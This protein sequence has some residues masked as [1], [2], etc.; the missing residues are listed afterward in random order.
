MIARKMS[1]SVFSKFFNQALGFV[2]LFFVAH[3]MGPEVLGIIAFGTAFLALFQSFADLGFGTAHIKRVSEGK[4]FGT[5]NGTYFTVKIILNITM[6]LT[7]LLTILISKYFFHKNFLSKEHEIVLYILLAA[8]FAGNLSMMFITTFSARQEVVKS[9]I[10]QII[11]KVVLVGGKVIVAI[12]GLGVIML[13]GISVISAAVILICYIY[14]FKGYPI[15]KPNKE[16]FK[17]YLSFA[18]PVIFMG[19]ISKYSANLDKIMIQFF[20]STR[21]VGLYAASK[22]ISSVL[23]SIPKS[24]GALLFPTI[25]QYHSKGNLEA[26][27]DL[28]HKTERYF[29]MLFFPIVGFISL[30][31]KQICLILLGPEFSLLTPE[32]FVIQSVTLL[33]YAIGQPYSLQVPATNHIKLAAVLSVITLGTNIFL[34]IIFIPKNVLGINLLGMGAIGAAYATLISAVLG[35][36]LN[37]IYAYK[38]TKSKPNLVIFIHFFASLIMALVLYMLANCF[39]KALWYHLPLFA[40]VGGAVYLAM[41]V[42]MR[43]FSMKELRYFLDILNPALLKKYAKTEIKEDYKDIYE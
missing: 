41:L 26:I 14:F 18:I 31:S 20:R 22:R 33:I 38:I 9:N 37:R 16:Y 4:D 24:S 12:C 1:F 23:D 7:V 30:F 34:N 43:E 15:K 25:S 29:S 6:T 10:A 17:N 40:F 32:I 5:C 11:G 36:I 19:F 8:N 27:R 13:A 2:S 3:Y 39:P 28:S 21:D 42:L 35:T